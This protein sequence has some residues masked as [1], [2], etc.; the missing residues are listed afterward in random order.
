M[1]KRFKVMSIYIMKEKNKQRKEFYIVY[2]IRELKNIIKS[3]E[4]ENSN[5]TTE[6]DTIVLRFYESDKYK[7]QLVNKSLYDLL[8]K[9][10]GD[11]N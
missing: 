7:G 6:S 1:R 8:D 2:N 4:K 9:Y 10:D 11:K 5:K 3:I